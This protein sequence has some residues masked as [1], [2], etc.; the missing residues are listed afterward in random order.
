MATNTSNSTH[1]TSHEARLSFSLSQ[2]I[3]WLVVLIAEC[4]A[5]VIIN[6]ITIIVFVKQRQLQRRSTYLIIHLAIVDLLVGAVTGPL[7]IEIIGITCDLW[8]YNRPDISWLVTLEYFLSDTLP[9][10]SLVNLAV[11]SSERL[12]ATFCPFKHRLIKKW[13]Y[14][15][16]ITVIWLVTMSMML[17]VIQVVNSSSYFNYNVIYLSYYVSL[18]L[19]ICVC[20]ISIY[21]KVRCNRHP[22]H[23]GA[24]GLRE[25]KM[26]STLFIVTLGSLLTFL[27]MITWF[28]L[29]GFH[30]RLI[31]DVSS[32]SLFHLVSIIYLFFFFSNSLINPIIYAMR[33]PELRAGVLQIIFRRSPN[34]VNPADF[35]LQNL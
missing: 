14:G 23:H 6:I 4:L 10:V 15:V 12:H 21:L 18:L 31:S 20:Y 17:G 1:N 5:I 35:P 11:I 25:R 7:Y 9:L 13:V 2:C 8:D 16:I 29:L 30:Q 34:R 19:V 24:A 28:S 33:M 26:T 27:P 32:R 3:P 22:Q